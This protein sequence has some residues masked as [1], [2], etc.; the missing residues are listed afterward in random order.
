VIK[1]KAKIFFIDGTHMTL[2]WPRPEESD[3]LTIATKVKNAL[4]QDNLMVEVDGHFL[5]FPMRN[6][7][8]IQLCPAPEKLPE[9]TVR[10]AHIVE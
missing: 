1:V 9:G 10:G 3:P 8:Y 6:I 4:E 5:V 2:A 7:K